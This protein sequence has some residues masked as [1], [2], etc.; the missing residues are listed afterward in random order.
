MTRLKVLLL[1][2]A[3][4]LA[5]AAAPFAAQATPYAFASNQITGLTITTTTG[6]IVPTTATTSISDTAQF[7]GSAPSA[8][9]ASGTVGGGLSILQAYSG[10]G[11][12]PA[13]TFAAAGPPG[14]FTGARADASIGAGNA[15]AGGV[16]VNNVAEAYGNA[17]GNSN[18]TNN[19]AIQFTVTG[20][21]QA[22]NLAFTDLY[23][24]I[25]SSAAL[26][27]ETANAAIQN[28]FSITAQG[29][30][31]PISTFSPA[32][33]NRQI[34][35]AAGTPA[36]NSVGPTSFAETFTSGVLTAGVNYNIALTST[37]SETIQNGTA[38]PP[39][40][41]PASLAVL[42]AGLFGL[43]MIRRR[44]A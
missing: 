30:T 29:S 16:A 25:A 42:G 8:F 24:L 28:N 18:G 26:P 17:L 12:A 23:Q 9:Q 11:S 4:T 37:A 36:T 5:V 1:T 22:L 27:G 33:L 44:K 6:S 2:G 32:E 14:A 21:G 39:V 34:A 41:E 7:M 43:G 10:P 35:S 19:A 31:T 15:G 20:T 38:P 13:A 40:P 3:A